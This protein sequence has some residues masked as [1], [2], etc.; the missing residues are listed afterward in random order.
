[1]K[2]EMGKGMREK[3]M[4]RERDENEKGDI[5]GS[6][7]EEMGSGTTAIERVFGTHF[8]LDCPQSCFLCPAAT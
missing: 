3:E 5:M 6:P 2:R 7:E 4:K 8:F 1:M